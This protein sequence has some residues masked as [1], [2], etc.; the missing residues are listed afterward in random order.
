MRV[1]G[2][3]Y[4]KMMCP[5]SIGHFVDSCVCENGRKIFAFLD[6]TRHRSPR[7]QVC[8]FVGTFAVFLVGWLQRHMLKLIWNCCVI[9]RFRTFVFREQRNVPRHLHVNIF[10]I[11]LM[12]RRAHNNHLRNTDTKDLAA[13]ANTAEK[14]K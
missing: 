6:C 8:A 11:I 10:I 13:R 5:V 12:F 1:L 14:I 2:I 3:R 7:I 4:W 9:A